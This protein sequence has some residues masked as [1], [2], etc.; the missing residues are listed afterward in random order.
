VIKTLGTRLKKNDQTSFSAIDQDP[1][2]EVGKFL[3]N[4][5]FNSIL[6]ILREYFIF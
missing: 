6:E 2:N 3:E 5:V 4:F 1:G